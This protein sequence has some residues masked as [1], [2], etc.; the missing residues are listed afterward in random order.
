MDKRFQAERAKYNN[1]H[2]IETTASIP[3][4]F[5]TMLYSLDGFLKKGLQ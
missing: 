1:F 2:I 5:C 4:R 3:T